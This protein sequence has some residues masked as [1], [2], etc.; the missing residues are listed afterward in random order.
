MTEERPQTGAAPGREHL[1]PCPQCGADLRFDPATGA[2]NCDFCGYASALQDDS[3]A[4]PAIRELDFRAALEEKLPEAETEEVRSWSCANCGARITVDEAVQASQCPFCATPIV[5]DTGAHRQIKPRGVLPFSLEE[6]AARRA[7]TD[8]LGRLWFAPGGL[9]K[10]ARKGRKLQG[11][12]VPFWTYDA[13]TRT[14]YTGQRGTAYYVTRTVM[15]DG[16]RRT[17]RQRKIR[18]RPV[19]G[20]VARFFDDVLILASRSLP[21]RYTDALEPWPLAAMEPYRPEFLAGFMAEGYTIELEEG[22]DEA[23][24]HMDRVIRRDIRFDIG[25]DEQRIGS[26][27]TTISNVTFKHILLPVWTAAYRYRGKTYRFV[28]NGQTGKVQGE[29][30]WSVWKIALAVLAGLTVAGLLGYVLAQ[31]R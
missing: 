28:V 15:R 1:F 31:S 5:L 26:V 20:R 24:R 6:A 10:Y 2:M 7:M 17:I 18:W 8:W 23:R 27:D 16:K 21:K 11:I 9:Q 13:D 19:S 14:R 12:Y 29:R 25:G 22:F 30:P 3:D 4:V